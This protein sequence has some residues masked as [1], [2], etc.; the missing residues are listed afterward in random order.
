MAGI[1]GDRLP[2]AARVEARLSTLWEN[3][4][5]GRKSGS[6]FYN[7]RGGKRKDSVAPEWAGSAFTGAGTAAPAAAASTIDEAQI[8][9][10]L[11]GS[12]LV[13]SIRVLEEGIVQQ[14]A[15][16]DLAMVLGTGFAPFRGG[17]LQL[18]D[19][20]GAAEVL[21]DLEELAQQFGE[22]FAPPE[23]LRQH[24]ASGQP[25]RSSTG[26]RPDDDSARP[27]AAQA[28]ENSGP[29]SAAAQTYSETVN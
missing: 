22:R 27:S 16:L 8:E 2:G 28:A 10:R 5:L 29:H 14:P 13:E 7:Y 12:L 19:E 18:V 11:V 25:F 3:G 4:Q 17:P 24:V 6:G 21:S 1:L 26:P 15:M 20:R 23:L 9:R